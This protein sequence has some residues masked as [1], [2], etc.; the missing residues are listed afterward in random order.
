MNNNKRDNSIDLTLYKQK[1]FQ[2]FSRAQVV[3]KDLY[4]MGCSTTHDFTNS[5]LANSSNDQDKGSPL[6]IR[7]SNNRAS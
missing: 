4:L 2:S 5:C 3:Q 7:F 1:S 6:F